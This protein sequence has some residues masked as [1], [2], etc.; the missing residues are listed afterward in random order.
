MFLTK[1]KF[2][3]LILLPYYQSICTRIFKSI[4][5]HKS[6]YRIL[7]QQSI[8]FLISTSNSTTMNRIGTVSVLIL[9]A[10]TVSIKCEQSVVDVAQDIYRTCLQEF[11][12]SCVKPK[13][14]RWVDEIS[15]KRFI[16]ITE[17]L[18]LRRKIDS[19]NEVKFINLNIYR[20]LNNVTSVLKEGNSLCSKSYLIQ[21]MPKSM[22]TYV[23]HI[24]LYLQR[25]CNS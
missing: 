9:F 7:I 5:A 2:N 11:S 16:K 12:F 25:I 23:C 6:I 1:N 17:D 24:K 15:R 8:L 22:F 20:V 14:N 4:S 19:E 3:R 21:L 13:A 10:L 18:G